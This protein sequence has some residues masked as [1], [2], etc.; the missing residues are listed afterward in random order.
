[1]PLGVQLEALGAPRRR[2]HA[3]VGDDG[4]ARVAV[5]QDVGGLEVLQ[6]EKGEE[7]RKQ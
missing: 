4:A 2:R 5:D 6:G 1:M 7:G 3:P